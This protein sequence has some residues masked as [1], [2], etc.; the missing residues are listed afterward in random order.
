MWY[1][2]IKGK[3]IIIGTP[4]IDGKCHSQYLKSIVSTTTLLRELGVKSE[5]I[6]LD[7]CSIIDLARNL[8]TNG[9]LKDDEAD[10]LIFVD[11]DMGFD[12]TYIPQMI[13]LDKDILT[14]PSPKKIHNWKNLIKKIT[15]NTTVDP[16]IIPFFANEYVLN[17]L[18]ENE[19]CDTEKETLIE[20]DSAGTGFTMIKRNVFLQILKAAED[21]YFLHDEERVYPFFKVVYEN[22]KFV[23]E[24]IYFSRRA[25]NQDFKIWLCPWMKI[26]H[27][28]NYE[29]SGDLGIS[30]QKPKSS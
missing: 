24:D 8:I 29:Y 3:K 18:N 1:D 14:A 13:Y 4:M 20:L 12:A 5:L 16:D 22:S 6:T 27:V 30:Y 19:L 28:G 9:F 17:V 26:I 23:G 25:K 11:S 15:E 2:K 7:G 21:S 10:Y